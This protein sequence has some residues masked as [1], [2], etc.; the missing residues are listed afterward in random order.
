VSLQCF[1]LDEYRLAFAFA[2]LGKPSRETFGKT[3]RSEAVAGFYAAIGDR[4]RVV[5]IGGIGEIAHAELVQPI[6]GT[7]FSLAA[8]ENV[9]GELLRVHASILA[10]VH[11]RE[12]VPHHPVC[13]NLDA[14]GSR[15]V[16]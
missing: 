9:D 15:K 8:N 12:A 13:L 10:S 7:G 4:K 6:E 5:K 1:Y 2:T 11:S 16:I 3:F 14:D